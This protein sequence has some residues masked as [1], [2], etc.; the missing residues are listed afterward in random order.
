MRLYVSRYANPELRS[1][2]YTA[3]RISLGTPKWP[4]GYT[5]NGAIEK[6]MPF[7]LL[8]KYDRY[9]DFKVEYFKKL[10]RVG[11]GAIRR[12]LDRYLRQGK[13][14][15]LLCYEDVRKGPED[16]CHRT[17]FAEWWLKNTGEVIEELQDPSIPK[18]NAPPKAAKSPSK[19]VQEEEPILQYSMF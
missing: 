15:V 9:E 2:K 6:L 11:V 3:V 18:V 12:E 13:D 5:L 10:D 8:N 7:G 4:L 16:W 17:A 1:G 19:P 14:V